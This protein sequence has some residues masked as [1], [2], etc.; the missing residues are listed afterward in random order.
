MTMPSPHYDLIIIGAGPAGL[1]AAVY[2]GREGLKTLVLEQGAIGGMAAVT[3]RIE[4][5]PGFENGVGGLELADHLWAHAKRFGADIQMGV[6][7]AGMSRQVNKIKVETTAAGT[8]AARSVL[9]A[10]GSTYRH[11]G[12]PGEAELIGRGVHFCAVCDGPLFR[13]KRLV[14][15]GGGNSAMQETLALAKFASEVVMLVRGPSLRGTKIIMDEV[16]ALPNVRIV[17]DT[18]VTGIIAE[19]QQVAAVEAHHLGRR[20][21]VRYPTDG[22]FVFI[23]LVANTKPFRRELQLDVRGFIITNDQYA[24][25]WAGVYAAGDVRSGSTWQ[26]ASAV[27]EGAAAALA[28]RLHLDHQ[29]RHLRN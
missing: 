14:V 17:Y 21:A 5:Y 18:V 28:I 10:S 4:N 24:T 2:A 1:A 29:R 6:T 8:Y 25:N 15:V 26:I 27:G 20:V 7:V 16:K 11:L 13:D 9:V 19:G 22:V 12:V 23:G 3:E